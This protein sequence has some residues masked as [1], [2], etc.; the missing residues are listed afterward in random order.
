M[1]QARAARRTK[2]NGS[3]THR[4]KRR[5]P[6]VLVAIRYIAPAMTVRAPSI[7]TPAFDILMTGG[8]S[9]VVMS[10]LLIW[11]SGAGGSVDFV[12]GQWLPMMVLINSPH[13]AASYRLLYVSR[14]EILEHRWSTLIVPGLLLSALGVAA[15][16]DYRDVIVQNLVFGSSVYL[17][18]H[19]TGQAWGMVSAFSRVLGIEFSSLERKL[20]RGGMRILLGVH[21][22]FAFSGRLPPA[23]WIS[24][25]SYIEAYDTV[26]A[27][28]VGLA[29]LSLFA[30]AWAFWQARARG[31]SIPLRV[32][33][34]W[35][36]LYIWYPF[37]YFVPGGFI[38]VQLS[39]GLQYLA[40]PLRVE[41]NRYAKAA[42]RSDREKA[43]HVALVYLGLIVA[44]VV[45]L[46]GPPFAAHA[47]GHGWYSTPHAQTLFQGFIS[48]VAIHH[49][50]VDGAIW[51]LSNPKVRGELLS[52]LN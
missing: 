13:F 46:H 37:W 32:V 25:A 16:T 5:V 15:L 10:G 26:F 20:I 47:F 3:R 50:F 51:K 42:P 12:D 43:L 31:Q 45:F 35:L 49:Y 22:L 24:P 34:P 6:E 41:V 44:G 48:C 18:W 39:H 36:A 17:A 11:A 9:I 38:W 28:A 21:V 1:T 23:D 2:E 40:F 8:L 7:T 4:G 33:F 27:G 14:E 52:H 19:Y 30:G 29:G